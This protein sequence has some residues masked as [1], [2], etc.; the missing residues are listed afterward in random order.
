MYNK[1]YCVNNFVGGNKSMKEKIKAF[2]KKYGYYCIAG[3]F[4]LAITLGVVFASINNNNAKGDVKPTETTPIVFV[5]PVENPTVIKWY[6]DSDLMLN[7]TLK[8]WEAHKG[9]DMSS[10]N[11]NV[12]TVLD[13]VVTKIETSYELGTTITITHTNGFVSTY[14]SLDEQL[15]V[16][17]G[18]QVKRGQQIGKMS[19]SSANE[20]SYGSHLHFELFK[21]GKKVDP[22][23]YLTLEN[24]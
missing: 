18:S 19:T 15:A 13:G 10:S 23:N 14:S 2:F 6:S 22:A 12:F 20:V 17:E 5:V 3:V 24:K 7:E 1:K 11:E 4:I 9:I 8:Q 21:D 16:K